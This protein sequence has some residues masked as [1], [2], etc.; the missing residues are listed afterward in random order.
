MLKYADGVQGRIFSNIAKWV[1]GESYMG[2]CSINSLH[3]WLVFK[4]NV[5]ML[6]IS[7][8]FNNFNIRKKKKKT[9]IKTFWNPKK[10]SVL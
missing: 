10:P 5:L 6:Y 4:V 9:K 8:H 2:A 3:L 1:E 7:T